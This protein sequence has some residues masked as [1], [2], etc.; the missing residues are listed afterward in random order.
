MV[1][2]SANVSRSAEEANVELGLRLDEPL[3]S[4]AIGDQT[5]T[6]EPHVNEQVASG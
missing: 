5:R 4:C 1:V 2:A 3:L 6:L